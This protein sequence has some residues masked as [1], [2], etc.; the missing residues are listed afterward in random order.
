MRCHPPT[1]SHSSDEQTQPANSTT[2]VPESS[3]PSADAHEPIDS[4]P[5][6]M[7]EREPEPEPKAECPLPSREESSDAKPAAADFD[8]GKTPDGAEKPKEPG[9]G[10]ANRAAAADS[11]GHVPPRQFIP[12]W[13]EETNSMMQEE[14]ELLQSEVAERDARIQELTAVLDNAGEPVAEVDVVEV[15]NLMSRLD[16]L[17]NE[18]SHGDQRIRSLEE[19]LRSAQE[20]NQAEQD[21]RQQIEKWLNDIECRLSERQS[22]WVAEREVL[23]RR[24]EEHKQ[25]RDELYQQ[26]DQAAASSQ[27]EVPHGA[28]QKLQQQVD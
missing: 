25:Q 12:S 6:P 9:D 2:T 19:L 10:C 27:A 4:P 20:A 1:E 5:D 24:L 16:D 17:L 23:L 13:D 8:S 15:E 22:E 11:S 14:I 7:S 26:L 3:A 18:L 28:L 21:E